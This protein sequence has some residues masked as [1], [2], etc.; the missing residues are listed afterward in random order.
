MSILR[1]MFFIFSGPM[2]TAKKTNKDKKKNIRKLNLFLKLSIEKING[3]STP[4]GVKI[5]FSLKK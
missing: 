1:K 2:A 5:T 3:T 4:S